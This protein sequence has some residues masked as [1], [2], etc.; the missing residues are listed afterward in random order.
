[1]GQKSGASHESQPLKLRD[2]KKLVVEHY[3][4]EYTGDD[5]TNKNNDAAL[6]QAVQYNIV[7]VQKKF[8]LAENTKEI[9]REV[10]NEVA[11]DM[12]DYIK[13]KFA[14]KEGV[15]DERTRLLDELE[16]THEDEMEGFRARTPD[17]AAQA[18]MSMGVT[19]VTDEYGAQYLNG[20]LKKE[21]DNP[22]APLFTKLD[23]SIKAYTLQRSL[24]IKETMGANHT[25][26]RGELLY[27]TAMIE[28]WLSEHMHIDL[29]GLKGDCDRYAALSQKARDSDPTADEY[30]EM[31]Q[32][33]MKLHNKLAYTP[34]QKADKQNDKTADATPTPTASQIKTEVENAQEMLDRIEEEI[35]RMGGTPDKHTEQAETATEQAEMVAN[36]K[37][38]NSF[39]SQLVK[40]LEKPQDQ[41]A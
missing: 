37:S 38:A 16:A 30:Q 24:K 41:S 10:A 15:T 19:Q 34:E 12:G 3:G 1:M 25:Q 22:N 36:V 11:L 5:K 39:L 4:I 14:A 9:T 31:R 26:E 35:K 17:K 27:L 21:Q 7:K 33:E 13:N 32:L 2:V 29:E 23:T 20:E 6:R 28:F 8:G 18:L 40:A